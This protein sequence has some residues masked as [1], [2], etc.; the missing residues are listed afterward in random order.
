M[1]YR[2]PCLFCWPFLPSFAFRPWRAYLCN[3]AGNGFCHR[4]C[5]KIMS[6]FLTLTL[7]WFMLGAKPKSDVAEQ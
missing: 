4:V 1:T 7:S 3:R 5:M 6:M 2:T